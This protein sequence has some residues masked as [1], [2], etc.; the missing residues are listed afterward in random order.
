[1]ALQYTKNRIYECALK[2]AEK[3]PVNKITVRAIVEECQIT[4]NTFYYHFHDLHDVYVSFVDSQ[5]DEMLKHAD[6]D[7]E[8][9]FFD[10]IELAVSYKKVWLNLYKC[11]GHERLS[12]FVTEKVKRFIMA[13][14]S[15]KYDIEK[16]P[17]L[18]LEIICTFYGEA[19][20]GILIRW[21][22]DSRFDTKDKLKYS[23]ERIRILFDGQLETLIKNSLNKQ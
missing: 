5:I 7:T 16:I 21:L 4:R 3:R 22:K 19:V 20:F 23:L 10:F 2:M 18:D 6:T 11:V 8:A 12:G 1:M 15:K 17:A 13:S 9:A 14:V